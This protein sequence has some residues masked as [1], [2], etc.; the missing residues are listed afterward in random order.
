MANL[1]GISAGQQVL[2]SD[3]GMIGVV[4]SVEGDVLAV[5]STG[6]RGGGHHHVPADW[7]D[8]V[9]THVHLNRTAAV[10]WETWETHGGGGRAGAA[11]STAAGAATR[12]RSEGR[13]GS[14]LPWI[15]LG[16]LV[17]VALIA[18]FRGFA[19]QDD[20]STA[21]PSRSTESD[22]AR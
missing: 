17:L 3:G 7:I 2:G 10:A 11:T 14:L 8:R 13:K 12:P 4:E 1:G 5:R 18:L 9:D 6:D 21:E 22:T 19:Y 15:V 16:V 20:P